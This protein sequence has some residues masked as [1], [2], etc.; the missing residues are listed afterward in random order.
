MC[1]L[2]NFLKNYMDGSV[3]YTCQLGHR[4]GWC[5]C[6]FPL[7]WDMDGM[8]YYLAPGGGCEVLFSS[9]PVLSCP[10]LSCPVLCVCV[11]VRACVRVCPM[12]KYSDIYD[13]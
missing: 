13:L 4:C 3:I 6:V 12:L 2:T 7:S 9:C 8:C 11:C 1:V 5:A 10:V